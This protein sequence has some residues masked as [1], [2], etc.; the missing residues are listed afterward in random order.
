[1]D[2]EPRY[3]PEQQEF[4]REVKGWLTENLPD[5]LEYPADSMDLSYE[6][7]LKLRDIGRMLGSKGWLWPTAPTE[8]G[9]GG[10]S[11]DHA[12]VIEEELDE[13]GL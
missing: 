5:G 7:Y 6:G 10:L 11:I 1:M 4:R 9:G 8:Y 12:I 3:T 2:F 13:Q